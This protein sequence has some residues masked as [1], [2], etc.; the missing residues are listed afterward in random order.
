MSYLG[1]AL[2]IA[3]LATAFGLRTVV[4]VRRTGSTGFRALSRTASISERLGVALLLAG[5]LA[6]GVGAV[7]DAAGFIGTVGLL[8]VPSARLAGMVIAIAGLG[9]TVVAQFNMGS[10]WRIGVDPSEETDLVTRGLFRYVRNP[11]FLGMLM[12]WIGLALATPNVLCLGAPLLGL[13]GMEIQVRLVEEPYLRRVHGDA[14][15][16][17]ASKAGRFVPGVGKLRP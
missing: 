3:F 9:L 17:Y 14:Y 16:K 5:G 6:S 4:Q 12:F 8:D 10:S 13:A 2:Q 7:G 11:I 15:L 1:L